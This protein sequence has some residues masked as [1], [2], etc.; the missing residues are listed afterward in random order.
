MLNELLSVIEWLVDSITGAKGIKKVTLKRH[1][2]SIFEFMR[3]E[4]PFAA[5][6]VVFPSILFLQIDN[7]L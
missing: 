5:N 1:F 3:I 2:F 6:V 4:Q 7:V